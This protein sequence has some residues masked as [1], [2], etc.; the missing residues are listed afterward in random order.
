MVGSSSWGRVVQ[1]WLVLGCS[2]GKQ[3]IETLEDTAAPEA[4]YIDEDTLD[5]NVLALSE[6]EVET[7]VTRALA[8]AIAMNT[9][10]LWSA[11]DATLDSTDDDC[12]SFTYNVRY[13]YGSEHAWSDNCTTAG[14]TTFSGSSMGFSYS[15]YTSGLLNYDYRLSIS[16]SFTITR[17]DGSTFLMAGEVST[18][19]YTTTTAESSLSNLNGEFYSSGTD[20]SGTWLD[21][22]LL[23]DLGMIAEDGLATRKVIMEGALVGMSGNI[24]ASSYEELYFQAG[25]DVSCPTEPFGTIS[26][27]DTTGEWYDVQFHGETPAGDLDDPSLCDGC[28]DI[29]YRGVAIGTACPDLDPYLHWEGSPWD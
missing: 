29:L 20:E 18:A 12:P 4:S 26:I 17:S 9:E 14:G 27:R 2:G 13:S 3:A 25:S 8:M 10:V 6:S 15:N 16:S 5:I 22:G 19:R 28:G 23:V 1:L 21:Q 24:T 11:Y 7:E